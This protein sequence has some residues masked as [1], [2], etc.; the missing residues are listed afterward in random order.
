MKVLKMLIITIKD[1]NGIKKKKKNNVIR[2]MKEERRERRTR[3]N[4]IEKDK[5]GGGEELSSPL[6]ISVRKIS[7]RLTN[8]SVKNVNNYY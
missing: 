4:V 1:S 8:E 2:K 7:I 6:R 5:K 3:T